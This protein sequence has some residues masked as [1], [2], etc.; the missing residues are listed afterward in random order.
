MLIKLNGNAKEVADNITIESLL[1]QLGVKN[2]KAV[3]VEHNGKV[4]TEGE[5]GVVLGKNDIVEVISF[6]GGG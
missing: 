1:L 3:F 2:N 6:V 5:L 4:L